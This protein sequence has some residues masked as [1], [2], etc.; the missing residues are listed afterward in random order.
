MDASGS[1]PTPPRADLEAG[2]GRNG[3]GPTRRLVG[4][5]TWLL[6]GVPRSG[7]SLCCRLAAGLPGAV[8]LNEPIEPK[9][10][11][12][13]A[14]AE[15]AS[16]VI[17]GFVATMRARLLADGRAPSVQ[18]GGRLD[19]ARVADA[20]AE[21]GLRPPVGHLGEIVVD[22]ALDMDFTLLVRHN[23]LFA[24][25]LPELS[26]SFP[27]LALVRN[28]VA[29][30]ASWATVDLPVRRGRVP[31]GERFDPDLAVALAAERD[32]L[33]RRVA[34][35]GWFFARYRAHVPVERVLRYED[36]VGGGG[37]PLFRLLGF[38]DAAAEP[39][40]SRNANPL[41]DGAA[42]EGILAA[43]GAVARAWSPWYDR[44]A[45]RDA[46]AALGVR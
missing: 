13:C 41:Y 29:V 33:D 40:G 27:V 42:S 35:L 5:R 38:P 39:L 1:R 28:P 34:V 3:H 44:G 37:L 20:P 15:G 17:R 9:A 14:G 16:S 36:V 12:G 2:V 43:A 45:L 22:G 6:T 7:T 23:A 30:L 18:V 11:D 25:L 46:A 32:V 4:G 31:M 21:D 19:D 24:A 8:A 26:A 10:F